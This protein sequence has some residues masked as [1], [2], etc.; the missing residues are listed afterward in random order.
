MMNDS[1]R[2]MLRPRR[3]WPSAARTAAAILV[4]A[5]L[6]L[7]ATACSGSPSS[8]GSGGSPNAGGSAST[9]WLAYS[10]CM[11]TNG[12]PAF[13]DP[14]SSGKPRFPSAQQLG[15]TSSK[16]Q[17][18]GNACQHLQ[19][20]GGSGPTQAQVQ[21]YRNSMLI[22]ARCMRA[23]GISNFP[24]PD[25][26]GHLNIGPGTDVPVNTPQFQA[27]Y[28]VCVPRQSPPPGAGGNQ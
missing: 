10:Q 9:R 22:Y 28:R 8:T 13:P 5:G 3:A 19:P 23:H 17:A 4:A 24:D 15:V 1:T 12:V 21:Q 26:R 20:N 18:A 25:S 16:L 11:R 7:L 14:P 6:T 27:A 2:V